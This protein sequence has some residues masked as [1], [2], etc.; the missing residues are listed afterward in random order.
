VAE[1]LG[2][3]KSRVR[4]V[5]GMAGRRK[6]LEIEGTGEAELSAAFPGAR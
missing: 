2:L 4:L 3:A 1:R 5:S 6:V